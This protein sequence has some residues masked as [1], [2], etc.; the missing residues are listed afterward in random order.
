MFIHRNRCKPS[1]VPPET[2]QPA[3]GSLGLAREL[4]QSTVHNINYRLGG[5]DSLAVDI[6]SP[7]TRVPFFVFCYLFLNSQYRDIKAD[8]TKTRGT[9]YFHSSVCRL[10]LSYLSILFYLALW[11][12]SIPP[13]LAPSPL[14]R[15]PRS[16]LVRTGA[17]KRGVGTQNWLGKNKER[18]VYGWLGV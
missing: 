3:A 16:W 13:I 15:R 17:V 11:F 14:R 4:T 8:T 2:R 12:L 9:R 6:I 7:K 5:G 10:F 1:H 18:L